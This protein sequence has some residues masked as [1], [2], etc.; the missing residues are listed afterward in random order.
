MGSLIRELAR[1]VDQGGFVMWPLIVFTLA[2]WYSLGNRYILLSPRRRMSV[3]SIAL[4]VRLHQDRG[5]G[6][7]VGEIAARMQM[8]RAAN[9]G[10]IRSLLQL[11][12]APYEE[13]IG[14]YRALVRTIVLIAP[15]A[16]LLGTVSGMIE[17][18]DS[19]TD[20]TF[21]SQEGGVANGISEA[22]VTTQLGLVIAIPGLIAGRLLDRRERAI[23]ADI[24]QLVEMFSE[25]GEAEP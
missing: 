1:Y 11:A 23:R 24:A 8:I 6:G 17:M 16:G 3:R 15:L 10:N 21:F 5:P 25:E 13:R 18:F 12:A 19:L 2:L 7:L 4:A 22:L 9:R 14:A 20:M